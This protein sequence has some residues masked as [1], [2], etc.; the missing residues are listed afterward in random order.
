MSDSAKEK[1]AEFTGQPKAEKP[2]N[3][4]ILFPEIAKE[5]AKDPNLI[6]GLK[7]LFIVTILKKGVKKEEW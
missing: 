1:L 2:L 4:S 6:G 3:S 5:I 7:G